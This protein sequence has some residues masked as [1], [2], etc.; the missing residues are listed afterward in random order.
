MYICINTYIV[1]VNMKYTCEMKKKYELKYYIKAVPARRQSSTCRSTSRPRR[2]APRTPWAVAGGWPAGLSCRACPPP[3]AARQTRA[4]RPLRDPWHMS[5]RGCMTC[6]PN[7]PLRREVGPH[8]PVEVGI[9]GASHFTKVSIGAYS[10][11]LCL[12]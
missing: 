6:L 1:Y 5:H 12:I 4:T 8:R 2:R 11:A 9:A 3:R 10:Y 7:A